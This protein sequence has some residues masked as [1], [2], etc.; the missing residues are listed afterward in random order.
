MVK[1]HLFKRW[2]Q[3]GFCVRQRAF[4]EL[5]DI[6][7]ESVLPYALDP[8]SILFDPAT[9][10]LRAHLLDA[11]S[12]NVRLVFE[13][14]LLEAQTVRIRVIEETSA[15]VRHEL[16]PRSSERTDPLDLPTP[17]AW[18]GGATNFEIS[19]GFVQIKVDGFGVE[20]CVISVGIDGF[21]VT[22]SAAGVP[23]VTVNKSGYLH[24]EHYR[25]KAEDVPAHGDAAAQNFEAVATSEETRANHLR[26]QLAK[27]MW[28]E[29]FGGKVDSKPSGPESIGVDV[30]FPGS[31]HVYGL[32]EHATSFALKATRGAGAAYNDPYRLYNLD[33]FEYEL[34]N[35][36]SLYGSVPFMIAHNTK[37]TVG[38]LWL[39]SSEMWVDV[40]KLVES[41]STRSHW[42]AE[43]GILDLMLFL[44]PR[45]HDVANQLTLCTGRPAMPQ[46]FGLG[47]HQ[48]RW[49][50][51]DEQDVAEVDANFDKFNIP[52]DSLWLDIEH[53]NG[54]RYFT[55]DKDKFP[56]PINMQMKLAAKGR[57]MVAIVDPHI[58]CDEHFAV[59]R[60]AKEKDLFV[61]KPNG[62]DDFTG[63]CWPDTANWIDFLN[64]DS[65]DFWAKLFEF[66][67]Y[68]GSTPSLFVWNDMNEPSVFDGPE[69]S[70]PKDNRHFGGLEH[71]DVHNLYGELLHRSSFEGLLLRSGGDER[72]F[73]ISR[74]YFIGSQRYGL[75]WTGD[76]TGSWDHLR[77]SVPMI[78]SASVA[79]IVFTGADIGGFFGNPEPQLLVRWYQTAA[80]QPFFRAHAHSHTK[81]REPWVF[82]DP[83]VSLIRE[84]I[85]TRYRIMPYVYTLF[86]E[87]HHTG[88]GIM[89]QLMSEFPSDSAT[90]DTDDSFML[91]LTS[92][93]TYLPVDSNWYDYVTYEA[94]GRGATTMETP[95]ERT[96]V[97]VRGGS[98]IP[99]RNRIRCSSS[100]TLRD[101]FTL[102]VAVDDNCCAKGLLYVDDGHSFDHKRGAYLLSKFTF[103]D[104]SLC[105][106]CIRMNNHLATGQPDNLIEM[107]GSRVEK[108]IFIGLSV[109]PQ[110]I[111]L[112]EEGEVEKP[113]HFRVDVVAGKVDRTNIVMI[114]KPGVMFGEDWSIN[115]LS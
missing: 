62:K 77:M 15:R 99:Q 93:Q 53:T 115:L 52:Y 76:N 81:R 46:Y 9:R 101:P 17:K 35:P 37:H 100:M 2:D 82:G 42:M 68:K 11:A 48:S 23:L 92:V 83:Y 75:V 98:I 86:W 80:F 91:G 16:L 89:R 59:W 4:A 20:E 30:N 72:P 43:S 18:A 40:E 36:M 10:T 97:L 26:E 54:K 13:L 44:G 94:V 58:R 49:N 69:I 56:T 33:V 39:N 27:A 55:W 113:L 34:D 111:V 114:E 38:V 73:V 79:G 66:S 61:K 105:A 5:A 78:L 24:Y 70:M 41:S 60:R 103:S 87:S 50:Y 108:V 104:G 90:F 29:S 14:D 110:R 96:P 25:V 28:E 57:K 47:Y 7:P 106:K 51:H 3:S 71:R 21:E 85:R 65:R 109:V 74:A 64:P 45:P 1:R 84:A 32:P 88:K 63:W 8:D 22:V 31:V 12:P 6:A 107:F 112:D 19:N 67:S 95:L 102:L